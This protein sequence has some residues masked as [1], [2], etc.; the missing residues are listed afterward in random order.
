MPLYLP[1]TPS[2]KGSFRGG[3]GSLGGGEGFLSS[4]VNRDGNTSESL[5]PEADPAMF[6]PPLELLPLPLT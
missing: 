6:C 4:A 3:E 1:L 2:H 5:V